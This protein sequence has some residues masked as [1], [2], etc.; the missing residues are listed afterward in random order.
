MCVRVCVIGYLGRV[1][2]SVSGKTSASVGSD[3]VAVGLDY[4]GSPT[5]AALPI[6]VLSQEVKQS[7]KNSFWTAVRIGFG[8]CNLHNNNN[9]NNLTISFGGQMVQKGNLKRGMSLIIT[10]KK[11]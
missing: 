11:R 10:E 7:L 3:V 8:F 4:I 6:A 5:S 2:K 9:N 1:D